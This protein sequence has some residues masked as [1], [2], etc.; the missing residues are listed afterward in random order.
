M[1]SNNS[2]THEAFISDA[3][4]RG[5]YKDRQELLDNAVE[6]LRRKQETLDEIR[7]GLHE[8]D[9]GDCLELDDAGLDALALEIA[10]EGRE[11]M[12]RGSSLP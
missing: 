7:K 12:N 1:V 6:L 10:K 8:L 3:L 2:S 5:L 11:E 4:A 9:T